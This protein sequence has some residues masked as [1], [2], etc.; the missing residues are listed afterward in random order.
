[1]KR[2]LVGILVMALLIGTAILPVTGTI[3]DTGNIIGKMHGN[4]SLEYQKNTNTGIILNWVEQKLFASDGSDEDHFGVSVSIYGNYALIAAPWTYY[5]DKLTG[6]AYIFE[7]DSNTW[8]Q[9]QK[10]MPSNTDEYNHFGLSVSIYE[11]YAIIGADWDD[12]EN[13]VD[14]GAAY[15]F[16]RDGS[17]WIEKAK[18][19]SSALPS[20]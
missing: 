10:L 12:N 5:N 20:L 9:K 14:A 8:N 4:Y 11:D 6:S 18:L 3:S 2:K 13:G 7:R 1:M 16:K 15:I 19:I 17:T